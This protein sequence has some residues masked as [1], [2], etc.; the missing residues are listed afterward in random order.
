MKFMLATLTMTVPGMT[1]TT[2][3]ERRHGMAALL[4]GR[5]KACNKASKPFHL[6]RKV[7]TLSSKMRPG[8]AALNDDAHDFRVHVASKRLQASNHVNEG[9]PHVHLTGL[10][11]VAADASDTFSQNPGQLQ[12]QIAAGASWSANINRTLP[13]HA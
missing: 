12:Q 10:A 4:L 11:A 8:Q 6:R 5:W 13:V 2:T 1:E 7:S 9:L 3:I